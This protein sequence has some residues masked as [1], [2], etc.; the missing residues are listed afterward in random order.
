M[1][2]L[3][4]QDI[5]LIPKLIQYLAPLPLTV[6]TPDLQHIS[7][8]NNL[9]FT[10]LCPIYCSLNPQELAQVSGLIY[11]P[12]EDKTMVEDLK[13]WVDALLLG[14]NSKTNVRLILVSLSTWYRDVGGDRDYVNWQENWVQ[15]EL[16][17][18]RA[19]AEG[20]EGIII[21]VD[22]QNFWANIAQLA[23]T[24]KLILKQ[25]EFPEARMILTN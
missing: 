25:S 5:Q 7:E 24:I 14:I 17:I 4:C 12:K 6:I 1:I 23:S 9:K 18:M 8:E 11:I 2:L 16:E 19:R 15:A 20:L 13:L 3:L 10:N 22:R 21:N